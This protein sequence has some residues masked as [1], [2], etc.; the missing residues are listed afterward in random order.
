MWTGNYLNEKE[1]LP[2]T[3]NPQCQD[4]RSIDRPS[5]WCTRYGDEL[6]LSRD[7]LLSQITNRVRTKMRSTVSRSATLENQRLLGCKRGSSRVCKESDR[8]LIRIFLNI[9]HPLPH[10]LTPLLPRR[11][12]I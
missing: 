11:Q 7:G 4:D 10:Q 1:G 5:V 12:A 9:L 6:D 3:I 8:K 2:V